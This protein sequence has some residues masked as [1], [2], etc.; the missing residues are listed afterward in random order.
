MAAIWTLTELIEAAVRSGQAQLAS[1]ALRLL[2]EATQPSATDWGLGTG[3]RCQA[4]VTE[5]DEADRLYRQTIGPSRDD[6]AKVEA[7]V[8]SC[9]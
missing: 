7:R 9:D 3:S 4:L 2:I 1:G 8:R 5:G 6:V